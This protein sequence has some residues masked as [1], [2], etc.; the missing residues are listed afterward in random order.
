MMILNFIRHG[1]TCGNIKKRYIGRTDE[2][3]CEEG[4]KYLKN[5]KYP[6]CD[7]VFSSPLQRCIQTAEIIYPNKKMTVFEGFRECDFGD[8]EGKNYAELS[9]SADYRKWIDSGGKMTFPNGENPQD[10]K[11][12]CTSEFVRAVREIGGNTAVSLVV[13]GGTIMAVMEKFGVPQRDYY[14]WQTENGHGFVTEY[15]GGKLTVL[16]EI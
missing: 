9:G 3:L 2:G 6:Y 8:F 11:E 14:G 1:K 4:I 15:V 13:H 5:M 7:V 16:E 10:F 12:R